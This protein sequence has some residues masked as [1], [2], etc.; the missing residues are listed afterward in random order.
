MAGKRLVDQRR[1]RAKKRKRFFFIVL[2]SFFLVG[3]IF[4][5]ISFLSSLPR[6][7]I[8]HISVVGTDRQSPT[9]IESYVREVLSGT[10]IGFFPRTNTFFYPEDKIEKSLLSLPL[11]Q[12]IDISRHGFS[13]LIVHVTEREETA[14]W[15]GDEA[16]YSIDEYGYIFSETA[17]SSAF[18]YRG[19]I[20]GNPIGQTLLTKDKF[21]NMEFFIRE[22]QNLSLVPVEGF[23][24]KN[25]YLT[26]TLATGGKL[27]IYMENNLSEVLSTL[28]S[29]ISDKNIAPSLDI[30]LSTLIHLKLDAG[31]KVG[32][33]KK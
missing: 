25:G 31:G 2:Y 14:R 27:Y 26:V 7:Q 30:F 4:C 28:E 24:S 29:I 16:C 20:E 6:F 3:V 15:C 12:S 17:S 8:Q 9:I 10:Y 1:L 11:I 18:V 19:L 22:I 23:F 33:K 32:Y 5:G 21:R 13:T